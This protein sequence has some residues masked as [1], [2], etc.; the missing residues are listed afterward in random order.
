MRCRRSRCERLSRTTRSTSTHTRKTA[1]LEHS[2]SST[3][4]KSR[5]RQSSRVSHV[6]SLSEGSI[7]SESARI[8]TS[9]LGNLIKQ[10]Q[11]VWGTRT[12]ISRNTLKQCL[13]VIN[14]S[15]RTRENPSSWARLRA[16]GKHSQTRATLRRC[17]A[18]VTA[19][20]K[21]CRRIS[22]K[23]RMISSVKLSWETNTSLS[24]LNPFI[25]SRR[26]NIGAFFKVRLRKLAC[27]W[28]KTVY[29]RWLDGRSVLLRAWKTCQYRLWWRSLISRMSRHQS[30]SK[31]P[32]ILPRH[33]IIGS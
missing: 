22:K 20:Q 26:I 32:S 30:Q 6:G 33:P 25:L 2:L 27:A 15:L 14:I 4:T 12:L 18:Q 28:I 16:R 1:S 7:R 11:T 17:S 19:W 10:R 5:L 29:L 3:R 23:K 21:N 13:R 24:T 9:T 8:G 31:Q